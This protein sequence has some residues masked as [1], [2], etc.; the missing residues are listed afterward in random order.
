MQ[1]AELNTGSSLSLVWENVS[2]GDSC[3]TNGAD[4]R[5]DDNNCSS[6]IYMCCV[7][8]QT[9]PICK[10]IVTTVKLRPADGASFFW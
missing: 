8:G 2:G 5:N 10:V 9:N 7:G 1:T 4:F 6:S 3:G